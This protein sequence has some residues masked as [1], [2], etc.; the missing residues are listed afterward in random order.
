MHN[1]VYT[2]V[3]GGLVLRKQRGSLE[4]VFGRRGIIKSESSDQRPVAQINMLTGMIKRP[5]DQRWF[6][7]Y[8]AISNSTSPFQIGR[9]IHIDEPV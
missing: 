7:Y 8:E 9:Y 1:T 3:D 4:N 2:S 6:G 5:L